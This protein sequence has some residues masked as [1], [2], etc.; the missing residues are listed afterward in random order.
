MSSTTPQGAKS[1]EVVPLRHYG[2]WFGA[3]VAIIVVGM[4]AHTLYSKIPTQTGQQVC[5]V[6]NG[7]KK[8][9]PVLVW[10]FSWDVVGQYFF[11]SEILHGLWLTLELTVVAMVIGIALGAIIAIMRLSPN[12]LLSSTAWTYTWF[13]RGTPVLAQLAFWFNIHLLFPNL[14]VGVPFLPITF[15]HI[16][17]I[18]VFTPFVAAI[19]GLGL[20]EGAYMSEI[21]RSGL[22]S[23]DEGQIEAATSIGMTRAQTL[24]LVIL[25][26]AM[27][28]TIPPTGNEVISMLK[29]SSIASTISVLEL[30]GVQGLISSANYDIMP[31]LIVASLWY[32]V[33]T[34]ILSIGQFYLERYYARGSLRTQPLTPIQR[35]R[36]DFKGIASKIRTPRPAVTR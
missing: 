7:V 30:F 25:P 14:T 33:V 12:R 29:T 20:N 8:C 17:T 10:R 27:R 9:S 18:S 23:V 5:H 31:L 16:D 6:V 19:V 22:I 3:F 32:I 1:L 35:L 2:R 34:T 21:V 4:I 15:F 28:V 13:F 36:R 11:T 24:R 26:Q